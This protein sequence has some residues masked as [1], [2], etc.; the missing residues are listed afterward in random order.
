[1]RFLSPL[2]LVGLVSIALPI[3]IHLLVKMRAK[4][5][6]F[7][8]LAFLRETPS[9]R[10]RPR[11]IQQPL[12]LAL[13]IA[14]ISFLVLGLSR[15][16]FNI[17]N[18][19]QQTRIVL[20]DASLSMQADGRAEVAKELARGLVNSLAAGERAAIISF[21]SESQVLSPMTTSNRELIEAIGRY[22]PGS[23]PANYAEGIRAASAL[24]QTGAPGSASIDI[25]SDFQESGLAG[26]RRNNLDDD[27]INDVNVVTHPVGARLEQNAFLVEEEILASEPHNQISATE[28]ISNGEGQSALGRNW[29]IDGGDGTRSGLTWRTETNGQISVRLSPVMADDFDSDDERYLVFTPSQKRRALLIE[30]DGDDDA[31]YLSA[32][33]EAGAT[34]LGEKQFKVERLKA[35]P[36]SSVE[37]EPFSLIAMTLHGPPNPGELRALAD[38]ARAGGAVWLCM[39]KDVDPAL[40]SQFANG[41]EGLIFPVAAL[42]RRF[43]A[44]RPS[45]FGNVD[46]DA[47]GMAFM[48]SQILTTLQ[49]TRMLEG[50]AVTPRAD[51]DTLVRWRDGTPAFVG[52]DIG[53]G[54]IFLLATSPARTSGELGASAAFPALASSIVHFAISP[55]G[56][57]AREIG[58][59]VNLGLAPDAPVNIVDS[60]GKTTQA[61]ARDLVMHPI[62]YFPSPGIYRVESNGLTNYF[63]FNAAL[64]ESEIPLA[65][66]SEVK[67]I[68]KAKNP[69]TRAVTNAWHFAA[70]HLQGGWRYFL[71]LAFIL[72]V[73]ELLVA[74]KQGESAGIEAEELRLR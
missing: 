17:G 35:L 40:W 53:S 14:A 71:V 19:A 41:K 46:T 32:A 7:P 72:F 44:T 25:V 50:F 9:F 60:T 2:S 15:P 47:P 38:Y 13:R 51:A 8:S 3:A 33:L 29:A 73:A 1:M 58:Q 65:P 52:K 70:E 63:A 24:L 43:D 74:M 28:I 56:P 23:G 21:S 4:R 16:L 67:A 64:T 54:K 62:D 18:K 66:A 39:G 22:R 45:G 42:E 12:L 55:R 5:I 36:G 59:P 10:L 57:L 68:F 6:D 11:R 20:L 48:K 61:I 69:R 49:S 34:E 26:A 27:L 30:P 31:Q 37:L